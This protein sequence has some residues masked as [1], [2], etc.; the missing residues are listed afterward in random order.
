M[1]MRKCDVCGEEYSATY[2]S[3]PFCEEKEALRR[4]KPI[5]RHSSDFRNRRGGHALGV[6][7]LL[8]ALVMIGVG[9]TYLFGDNIAQAL[10]I[11]ESDVTIDDPSTGDELDTSN[12]ADDDAD[13]E[14]QQGG[15]TMPESDGGTGGTTDGSN[16]TTDTDGTTTTPITPND[17]GQ[18]PETAVT[19]SSSDFTLNASSGLQYTLK[20][21]GG[22]GTYTWTSKDTSVATVSENGQVSG[23]GNGMTEVTVTDGYTTATCIVRVKG[24]TSGSSTPSTSTTLKLNRDDMTMPAGTSFQLKVSGT[25]SAVTWSIADPSVATISSDGTV[26]FLK[27]GTTTATATVDGQTLQ[28]IVRVT[29]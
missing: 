24:I 12:I 11:R 15:T 28:C 5:R 25:S 17:N 16:Q 8:V 29:N 10:G 18:K 20:A 6:L 9:V 21:S 22:S 1:E 3:C 19:L 27:K 13:T 4:G 26:K 23:V 2:R 7:G 14:D